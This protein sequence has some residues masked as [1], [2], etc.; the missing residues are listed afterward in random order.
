MDGWMD[1]PINGC[2]LDVT[3]FSFSRI[4]KFYWPGV[5][6]APSKSNPG[7][8]KFGLGDPN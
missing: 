1:V 5:N 3:F 2:Q 8:V 7:N 4:Y 6:K